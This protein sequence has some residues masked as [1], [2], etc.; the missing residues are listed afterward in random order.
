MLNRCRWSGSAHTNHQPQCAMVPAYSCLVCTCAYESANLE[1]QATTL[2]VAPL[3]PRCSFH[4]IWCVIRRAREGTCQGTPWRNLPCHRHHSRPAAWG[5]RLRT[6]AG[7]CS[8][9]RQAAR[10]SGGFGRCLR[11]GAGPRAQGMLSRL[12]RGAPPRRSVQ[13]ARPAAGSHPE[14]R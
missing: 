8:L 11:E 14:P 9:H 12:K 1:K 5:A 3:E 4:K 13:R 2:N 6:A 7:L 10:T